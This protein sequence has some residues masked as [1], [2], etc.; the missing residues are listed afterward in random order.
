MPKVLFSTLGMTDPIKNDHDGPFLHIMRHYKPCKAYLFMTKR[1]CELADQDDRYRLNAANL[2][3]KE[4]FTCQIV[5]LRYKDIDNPQQFDIFYPI[6]EK[7]LNNIHNSNPGCQIL[8]NLSSGTPQMKSTCHLLALTTPF[9]VVPIQV[10]TPNER[11][12]YGSPDYDLEKSW[13]NNLD[14]HPDLEPKN[15][16]Q[17]VETENLRF[18]FLREAAISNIEA[19]NYTAALNIL[20]AVKDFVPEDVMRLL[21]AARNRKNMELGEAEKESKMA[22]YDLFPVKSGDV[23]EL[24]EYLLLLELQQRTGLL[25]DF[26]RGISPALSRLFECFLERKCQRH[27]KRDYC[28]QSQAEP[29]H[30]KIKRDKLEKKDPLLLAYYHTRYNTFFRDG[31]LS[32][33]TLLPMIE[34]DCGAGGRY[35][36]EEV[37]KKAQVMRSVEERIRNRAAHNITAI[38]EEQFAR[39][40]DIS[41]ERL[42]REMRWMFQYI[43]PKY[44]A[45]NIDAWD[46][47]NQMNAHIVGRLK[48]G[49]II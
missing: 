14:N 37:L 19:Y 16:A 43:Y 33:S 38:K 29:G 28:V 46:S 25:M 3:E 31:D 5:E 9:P 44:F 17:Q 48:A 26:V 24:F 10:T 15:R 12:N 1:V 35:P 34:F 8:V 36:N 42:L 27:V 20:T 21:R 32:C 11:E 18:L 30:W 39:A 23:K 41:S 22:Q 47:Y 13:K 45:S 6:F 40:A 2:C 49:V 7:E 4:G